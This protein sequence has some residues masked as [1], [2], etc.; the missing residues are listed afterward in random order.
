[1]L[2]EEWEK[3]IDLIQLSKGGFDPQ[4]S[5]RYQVCKNLENP[6]EADLRSRNERRFLVQGKRPKEKGGV[7][8]YYC[9]KKKVDGEFHSVK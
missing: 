6:E 7:K 3:D 2:E 9:C 5:F 8:K 4:S 1:L